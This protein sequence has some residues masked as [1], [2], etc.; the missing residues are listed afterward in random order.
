MGLAAVGVAITAWGVT[1][2]LTKSIDMDA[3]A[4][5]FWRF[6]IYGTVLAL[7]LAGRRRP[8][9][10]RAMRIAAPSGLMLA[11]DV[12]LFFTAVKVTNVVNATTIGALQP[13][14]IA[15][16]ATRLF[17]ERIGRR[18]IVA[19]LIAIV[20]V[21]VVVTQSSGTPQW[22]GAGD[23]AAVGALLSWSAYFVLAKRATAHLATIE[24][25]AATAWWVTIATLPVGLLAGEHMGV[26]ATAEWLPLLALIVAG[27]VLGHTLMNWGIPRVPLWLSSTMTLLIPVLASIA[28]WI[29]LD[30]PL[31]AWQ[32]A[33]MALVV[34]SLGVIVTAQTGQAAGPPALVAE[35]AV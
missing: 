29:F 17:G 6:L 15:G 26:P 2:V 14:V 22:S 10:W 28:A 23:L 27:G 18:E 33:A 25:T 13:L 9:T 31:T 30:E 3:I 16:A 20:G 1:G 34:A 21:V 5:A 4:I 7:W 11:G 19:A 8:L 35:P 32:L 24:F 12:M